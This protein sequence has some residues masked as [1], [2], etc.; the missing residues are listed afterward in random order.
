[1]HHQHSR[2]VQAH[3]LQ[4]LERRRGCDR[5]EVCVK[6]RNAHP[7][8][9]RERA[10]VI[11]T[12]IVRMNAIEYAADLAEMTVRR[13]ELSQAIAQFS[14]QHAIGNLPHNLRTEDARVI[15]GGEPFAGCTRS[16]WISNSDTTAG[17]TPTDKPSKGSSGLPSVSHSNGSGKDS[18]R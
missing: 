10:H 15:G 13:S 1:M 12:G 9:A 4:I 18:T 17:E 6:G 2:F 8:L 3:V 14:E 5:F 16:I 11:G 7:G